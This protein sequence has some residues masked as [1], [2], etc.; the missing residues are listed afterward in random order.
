MGVATAVS[1][2]LS[3]GYVVWT[4]RGGYLVASLL[5]SVPAWQFIDPL[6]VL[7]TGRLERQSTEEDDSLE[8][9]LAHGAK[10]AVEAEA[11]LGG[12]VA[13]GTLSEGRESAGEN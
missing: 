6:P 4:L 10:P 7:V 9:L 12:D 8:T 11:V 3:V 5:S 1:S 2:A 13:D